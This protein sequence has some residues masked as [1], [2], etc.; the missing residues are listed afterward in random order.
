MRGACGAQERRRETRTKEQ[1][2]ELEKLWEEQMARDDARYRQAKE[3]ERLKHELRHREDLERKQVISS[4]SCGNL[5]P[6]AARCCL[7]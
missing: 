5:C 4:S 7:C 2:G 3:I 6:S 1:R